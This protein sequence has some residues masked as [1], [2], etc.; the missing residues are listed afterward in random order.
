MSRDYW[1]GLLSFG[2]AVLTL[3]LAW[4]IVQA[5]VTLWDWLASWRP[6]SKL[7]DARPLRDMDKYTRRRLG[8]ALRKDIFSAK[9]I[10]YWR[11][12]PWRV[13]CVTFDHNHDTRAEEE[14]KP[15]D[16]DTAIKDMDAVHCKEEK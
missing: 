13:S 14:S 4:L 3:A 10:R 8:D 2:I 11:I 6:K 1:L 7:A 12:G 15:Y 5:V 9:R 16:T